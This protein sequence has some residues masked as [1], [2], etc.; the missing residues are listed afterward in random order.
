MVEKTAQ[1][2]TVLQNYLLS[3]SIFQIKYVTPM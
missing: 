3:S 2:K 1:L